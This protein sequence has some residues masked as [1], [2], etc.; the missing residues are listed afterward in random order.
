MHIS[1]LFRAL[2][3]AAVVSLPASAATASAPAALIVED[4]DALASV[5]TF[6]GGQID[7]AED[8]GEARACAVTETGTRCFRTEAQM[9]RFLRGISSADAPAGGKSGWRRAASTN[10]GSVLRLYDGTWYG[11]TVLSVAIRWTIL[12]LANYGFDN[13]TSSYRVGACA[14]EFYSGSW[15][16]GSVYSGA[17]WAGASAGT[18]NSGWDNQVSS[19]YIF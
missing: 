6:E 5:A 15:G 2:A 19:I 16:G 17:T 18:M 9:D 10:C 3:V 11:G 14:A 8:W 13:R 12:N 7:L 1:T 4:A